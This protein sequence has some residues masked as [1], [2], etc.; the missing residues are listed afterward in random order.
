MD[1]GANVYAEFDDMYMFFGLGS[2]EVSV[3]ASYAGDSE[4]VDLPLAAKYQ[5]VGV[6][7]GGSLAFGVSY[8]SYSDWAHKLSHLEINMG[9][10]F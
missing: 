1:Y 4:T 6:G 7:W 5:R 8:V 10:S 3:T 9:Y 2:A